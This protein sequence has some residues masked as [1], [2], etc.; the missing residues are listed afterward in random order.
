KIS[1]TCNGVTGTRVRV[2]Y[3]C[4]PQSPSTTS[5]LC[6]AFDEAWPCTTHQTLVLDVGTELA[7]SCPTGQGYIVAFAE[8]QCTPAAASFNPSIQACT[9][10]NGSAIPLGNFQPISFNQLFGSY[11]LFYSGGANPSSLRCGDVPCSPPAVGPTPDVEVADAIAI[12]SP[13]PVF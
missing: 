6:P 1:I 3:V 10:G 4:Q 12:Q 2:T 7:G 9:S 5:A 13:L 8:A 11:H